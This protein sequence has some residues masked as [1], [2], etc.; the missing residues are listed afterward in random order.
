MLAN[1]SAL[2]QFDFQLFVSTFGLI[3]V[4]E[5][6][7]KTAFATLLLATRKHPFAVFI[8]VAAAFLVQSLVAVTFGSV[9]GLLPEAWVKIAAAILF[10]VFAVSMWFRK[11]TEEGEAAIAEKRGESFAKTV[12][13]SFMV[14][15]I[16]EWGDLTQLATVALEAKYKNPVTIFTAATLSLWSV[17]AIA[18]LIGHRLKKMI[19][20]ILLQKVAAVAFAI[21]GLILLGGIF[22]H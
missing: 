6:P 8:G 7:D 18:I 13:T 21:V 17:T 22:S 14:I 12:A 5:L 15:F 11:E 16:A 3:F 1:A 9:L 10:F 2:T 20:P 19:Q 4:A